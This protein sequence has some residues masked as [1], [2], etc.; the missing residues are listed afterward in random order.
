MCFMRVSFQK[1]EADLETFG[2]VSKPAD[3]AASGGTL[4]KANEKR[5]S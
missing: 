4:T 5:D 3:A 2:V 1:C